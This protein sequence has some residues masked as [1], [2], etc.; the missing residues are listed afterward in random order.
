MFFNES[1][2]SSCCPWSDD[3]LSRRRQV[4]WLAGENRY[5]P[6]ASCGQVSHPKGG[7]SKPI[8]ASQLSTD[9]SHARTS[10]STHISYSRREKKAE[11]QVL[12][13]HPFDALRVSGSVTRVI[14]CDADGD[15]IS[16]S[17]TPMFALP[18][19]VFA[20]LGEHSLTRAPAHHRGRKGSCDW[21]QPHHTYTRMSLRGR[22]T[23]SMWRPSGAADA[24][25]CV[26][27]PV[28]KEAPCPRKL[29]SRASTRNS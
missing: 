13:R 5:Q 11:M 3:D 21:K 24:E 4:G 25:S 8:P 27:G 19:L 17:A 7:K 20:G 10:S 15:G 1:G 16:K 6:T 23:R 12:E 18:L 2:C 28:L 14:E 26:P 9:E 29:S 22:R